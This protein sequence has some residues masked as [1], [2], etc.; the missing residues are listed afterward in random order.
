MSVYSQNGSPSSELDFGPL[1]GY[2]RAAICAAHLDDWEKAA[3]FFEEG[4]KRSLDVGDTKRY[5]GFYADVGFARFKSGNLLSSIK[6]LKL[7]LQELEKVPQDNTDVIYFTLKKR[8]GHTI[9]WLLQQIENKISIEEDMEPPPGC[10]SDPET[11]E[12]I[13]NIPDY[14]IGYSWF[15]LAQIEYKF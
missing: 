2:R 15:C 6:L 11:K 5:I 13:L 14:P 7:A 9:A 4:A 10:C 1:D 12:K 3:T 8:L